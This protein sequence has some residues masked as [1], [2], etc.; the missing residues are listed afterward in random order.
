MDNKRS[1]CLQ[2]I[3]EKMG[4]IFKNVFFSNHY[5]FEN[6]NLGRQH[7]SLLFILRKNKNGIS[8]NEVAKKLGVT[9]G[10]VTQM[11]DK[12]ALKKLV[13]RHEDAVD[14]RTVK[15]KL[16]THASDKFKKFRDGYLNSMGVIF[17]KLSD[18][19]LS[20]LVNLLGKIKIARYANN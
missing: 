14:R 19:E 4:M 10:A 7:I 17:D 2:Q 9:A 16:T 1:L 6:M 20:E 18:N 5:K 8:V 11:V 15:I 13:E 12:L 3:S